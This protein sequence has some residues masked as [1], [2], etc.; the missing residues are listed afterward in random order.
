[1]NTTITLSTPPDNLQRAEA[2][3]LPIAH[4]AYQIGAGFRLLR[5]NIPPSVQGGLMVLGDSGMPA[6]LDSATASPG[7][8][9]A[10][11]VQEC[12]SRG[13]RGVV[14]AF[15]H[16][17]PTLRE[18]VH[19]L[20]A[21]LREMGAKL[22][23]PEAYARES[24]WANILLSTAMSGGSLATRLDETVRAFGR[25]RICLDIERVRMDFCLPTE[26]G[27]GFR[28]SAEQF[29]ALVEA[30]RPGGYFSRDLCAY[31]FTYYDH[32]GSHFV[33][34]DDAA[35]IREKIAIAQRLGIE[36]AM[37]LYPEVEDILPA[38]LGT[39]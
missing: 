3:R 31:Y 9:A 30:Y 18:V 5:A 12:V 2:Y 21:H 26:S 32:H 15:S 11:V 16:V 27:E 37:L 38:V 34:Y 4:M 17:S 7:A 25:A 24:E 23:L 1:M 13:Y 19:H 6:S 33:L 39:M 20:S 29:Y 28:L 36:Q 22:Y 35:S 8:L 10:E 14:L